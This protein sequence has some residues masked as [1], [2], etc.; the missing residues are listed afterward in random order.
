[1]IAAD[2]WL[3]GWG[4]LIWLASAAFWVLLIA[5]IIALVRSH[6]GGSSSF[7]G[8]SGSALAVLEERYARGEVS[9]EEFFERRSVLMSPPASSPRPDPES[10]GTDPAPAPP[11]AAA[12]SEDETQQIDRPG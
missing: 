11:P 2:V 8:G 6:G 9:R 12:G 4:A 5:G 10:H 7:G 1:M 3:D